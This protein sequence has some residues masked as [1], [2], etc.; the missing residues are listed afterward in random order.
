MSLD[1][2]SVWGYI[3]DVTKESPFWNQLSDK[4]NV[5]NR[6]AFTDATDP[7]VLISVHE[8]IKRNL[9]H[10]LL[11]GKKESILET[12][13]DHSIAAPAEKYFGPIFTTEQKNR[14][15]KTLGERQHKY[16]LSP[17]D[18]ENQWND[19]LY[20][21]IALLLDNQVEGLIGGS[22]RP[23]A[24]IVKA[25]LHCVGPKP[26]QK[27]ISGHFLIETENRTTQN[28]TPFLFADCAVVPEPSSRALAAI[29]IGAAASYRF[30]TRK[31]PKVALLSFST[32]GSAEHPL[33]DRI[34]EALRLIRS[35]EPGLDVDGELQVDAALDSQVAQI[36]NARDSRVTGA[37]NVFV[38][39][40]LEAGNIGYK[41]VQRFSK[42]RVAGPLLWGL[43]K[44]VSDL[45]RGCTVEEITDTTHCLTMMMRSPN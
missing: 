30:F 40:T 17:E 27:L 42:A 43:A 39:P 13:Q 38:F 37:A 29:A 41:L 3:S 8:I 14:L 22:T 28:N 23:T 26:G 11:I 24:E 19:P 15:K 45:S 31:T 7:R 1:T 9:A 5:K 44:P 2:N 18:L 25:A 34:R 16:N 21:G 6:I 36:K 32:R 10:P 20:Q 4:I 33:V 35:E 12:C